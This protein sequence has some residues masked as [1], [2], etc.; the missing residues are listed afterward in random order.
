VAVQDFVVI[1]EWSGKSGHLE[2]EKFKTSGNRWRVSWK[3]TTGDPDPIGSI[4]ITVRT[5]AG[6]LVKLASNLG[7]KITSGHFDVTTAPGEYYLEI[8]SAD[9]NWQV[10]AEQPK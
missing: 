1:K 6:A 9:R 10:T 8:D 7:Q 5:G 2:T 3:T 4:S